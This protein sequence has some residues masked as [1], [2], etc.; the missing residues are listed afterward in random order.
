MINKQKSDILITKQIGEIAFYALRENLFDIYQT[1]NKTARE[2][3]KI[4]SQDKLK[5]LKKA[6]KNV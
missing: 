4:F 5:R 1:E 3:V 6:T 2:V